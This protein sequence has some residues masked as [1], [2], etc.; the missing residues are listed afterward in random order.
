MEHILIRFNC[1]ITRI[2]P[3]GFN[4]VLEDGYVIKYRDNK[5]LCP[6]KA[7]DNID[8]SIENAEKSGNDLIDNNILI[9]V[10][11]SSFI[12]NG[13]LFKDAREKTG[14]FWRETR[15][16]LTFRMFEKDNI[17]KKDDLL[18]IQISKSVGHLDKV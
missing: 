16:L 3:D 6:F 13:F 14:F 17:Y 15:G 10:V 12:S 8:I 1:T 18:R 9:Y 2:F 11:V 7:D 5:I 4:A